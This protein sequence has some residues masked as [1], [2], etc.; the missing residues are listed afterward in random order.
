MEQF[1]I[2]TLAAQTPFVDSKNGWAQVVHSEKKMKYRIDSAMRGFLEKG[3][4]TL[5]FQPIS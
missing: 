1:A 5:V 3:P 2:A 4:K